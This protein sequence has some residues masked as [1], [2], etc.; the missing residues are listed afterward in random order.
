MIQR[1]RSGIWWATLLV[2]LFAIGASA[3]LVR[4]H[5]L[6]LSSAF[7]S[8]SLCNISS[9]L[10]CDLVLTSR[11]ASLGTLPLAGLG[12]VYYLYVLGALLY[13]RLAPEGLAENLALPA[14]LALFSIALSLFLA[15]VSI[16][17]LRSMCVFC[18]SL[19]AA[20]IVLW[21]L[22]KALIGQGGPVK[23]FQRIAWGK[24]L[25]YFGIVFAIGGIL[26]HTSHKQ[27]AKELS[28][29]EA[30]EYLDAF[31]AQTP[32]AIDTTGRPYWGNPDAKIVIA[33]FSDMECP[34]CKVAAFNLKPILSDYKDKVKLVFMN[35]PLDKSCNPAM[36]RELHQNAC[37]VA[38]AAHC[39]AEQGKFWE[40]HDAAFERQPRFSPEALQKIAQKLKLDMAAFQ[41]C[42]SSEATKAFVSADLEQGSKAKVQ[43]TP[44][45]FING[46]LFPNWISRQLVH[47]ALDKMLAEQK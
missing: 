34:F 15:Y 23:L 9:Y 44:T 5:F 29:S 2:V 4:E 38:Y 30:K 20:N 14:L 35:Y 43:G 47:R 36:E 11:Y 6:H 45:V 7:T 12:L 40:Y 17:Q 26:L 1:L 39:A 46:R 8:R 25:A 32:F 13:A 41:A 28:E 10:N 42:L 18:T 22:L 31:F 27:F 3:Y 24:S 19:Y 16:F 21:F 33:E 37:Q